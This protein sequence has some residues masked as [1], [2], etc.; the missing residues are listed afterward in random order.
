M[1]RNCPREGGCEIYGR[2][3]TGGEAPTVAG[4]GAWAAL[5]DPTAAET[6]RSQMADRIA[7]R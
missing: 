1:P 2:S 5:G 6:L 4:D 7:H 3:T